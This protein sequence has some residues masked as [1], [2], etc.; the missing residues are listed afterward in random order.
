VADHIYEDGKHVG[1]IKDGFAIDHHDNRR[2][3]VEHDRLIDLKTGEVV[4]HLNAVLGTVSR[5]GLF[6]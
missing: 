3:R 1:F 2:Y 5:R 4:G 6:D